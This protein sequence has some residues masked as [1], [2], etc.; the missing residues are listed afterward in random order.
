MTLPS[1]C[2]ECKI[3]K[4]DC[5]CNFNCPACNRQGTKTD[6]HYMCGWEDC[7]VMRFLTQ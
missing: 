5:D 4:K 7:R 3:P 1:Q 2:P 6:G